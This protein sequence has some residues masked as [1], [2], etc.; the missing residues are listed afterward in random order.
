MTYPSYTKVQPVRNAKLRGQTHVD[1]PNCLSY[2]CSSACL[3]HARVGQ[4]LDVPDGKLR[5]LLHPIFSFT[6]S[7]RRTISTAALIDHRSSIGVVDSGSRLSGM[8][9]DEARVG[10]RWPKAVPFVSASIRR[11]RL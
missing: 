6:Y 10:S 3:E 1:L 11:T 4:E 8:A 2:P 9:D 5:E 7:S